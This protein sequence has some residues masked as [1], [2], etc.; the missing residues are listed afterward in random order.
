MVIKKEEE[1]KKVKTETRLR[2]AEIDFCPLLPN[3][4][5]KFVVDDRGVRGVEINS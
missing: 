4:I 2:K 1:A 5:V 3:S